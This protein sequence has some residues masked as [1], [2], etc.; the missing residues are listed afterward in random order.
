MTF[1]ALRIGQAKSPNRM[2]EIGPVTESGNSILESTKLF[3]VANQFGGF[4]QIV[5]PPPMEARIMW[6]WSESRPLQATRISS[7]R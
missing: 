4:A 7:G 1:L 2:Q 3:T 5:L 6:Q